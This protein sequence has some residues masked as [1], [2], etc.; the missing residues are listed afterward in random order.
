[1]CPHYGGTSI[2]VREGAAGGDE[3]ALV[4]AEREVPGSSSV[5]V[6]ERWSEEAARVR[7]RG[8]ILS[9][10][11]GCW[12]EQLHW[13]WRMHVWQVLHRPAG[14]VDVEEQWISWKADAEDRILLAEVPAVLEVVYGLIVEETSALERQA[15]GPGFDGPQAKIQFVGGLQNPDDD[16]VGTGRILVPGFHLLLGFVRKEQY[17]TLK[18]CN[19]TLVYSLS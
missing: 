3:V 19:Q 6:E 4:K 15:R 9:L 14:V 10:L 18:G 1:M 5:V 17:V 8:M 12:S 2:S 11:Q 13:S 16:G 7:K